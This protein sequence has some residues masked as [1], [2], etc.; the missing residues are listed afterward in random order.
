MYKNCFYFF[1]IVE[2]NIGVR[3]ALTYNRKIENCLFNLPGSIRY[4]FS[5]S[6]LT[7]FFFIIYWHAFLNPNI[8]IF[9]NAILTSEWQ[10]QTVVRL[11]TEQI[12]MA[13]VVACFKSKS[14]KLP[15]KINMQSVQ[16]N[17]P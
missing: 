15:V 6:D 10:S 2:I 17:L 5:Y 14:E 8:V 4:H 7:R 12:S 3:F 1:F 16:M 11:F 13:V 9:C